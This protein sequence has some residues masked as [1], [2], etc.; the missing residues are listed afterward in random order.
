MSTCAN[1]QSYGLCFVGKRKFNS[2]IS[3]YVEEKVGDFVTLDGSVLGRHKGL[4]VHSVS[5]VF[6]MSYR[7][8]F[9]HYRSAC[10]AGRPRLPLFRRL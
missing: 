7:T 9:L 3:N 4:S 10:Q 5:A 2:F 6:I 1:G 8:P